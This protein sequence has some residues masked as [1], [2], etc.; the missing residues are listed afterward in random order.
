MLAEARAEEARVALAAHQVNALG[1]GQN[2]EDR[3]AA[4]N[5]EIARLEHEQEQILT[6]TAALRARLQAHDVA[7]QQLTQKD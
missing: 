7:L 3:T 4:L 5:A 1:Q 2:Q 6:H